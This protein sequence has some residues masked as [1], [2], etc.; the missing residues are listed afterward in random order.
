MHE[1]GEIKIYGWHYIIET[2]ELF[3]YDFSDGHFK[4]L[5]KESDY[6]KIYNQLFSDY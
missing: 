6:E 4:L 2:G 1:T 5:K 3:N